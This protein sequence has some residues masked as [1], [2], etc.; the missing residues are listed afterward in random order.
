MG[1]SDSKKIEATQKYLLIIVCLKVIFTVFMSTFLNKI[2]TFYLTKQPFTL[3][4][5]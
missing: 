2:V 5:L 4:F 3:D 1:N